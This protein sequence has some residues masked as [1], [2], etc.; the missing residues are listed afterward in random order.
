M[1][2]RSKRVKENLKGLDTKKIYTL[3]EALNFLIESKKVKFDETVEA[4]LHLNINPEKTEQNVRGGADL[5]FGTGKKISIAVFSENPIKVEE[6]KKNGADIFGGEELIEETAKNGSL[7]ADIV[8]ATPGI[9]PKLAKVARIL[10]PRGLMPNPK[11]DTVTLD[12]EKTIEKFKKGKIAF[13]NDKSGNIHAPI[14]KVSFSVDQLKENFEA[15]K[16]AVEKAR[17]NGVK[18]KYLRSISLSSTMGVGLKIS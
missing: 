10:G 18:G 5:P 15:L 4:H 13:K 3:E 6:A 17:P 9:M 12:I 1:K 11:N 2:Q 14:G 8:L 7:S 16:K